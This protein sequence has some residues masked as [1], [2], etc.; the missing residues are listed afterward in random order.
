VRTL[1][2]IGAVALIAAACAFPAVARGGNVTPHRIDE[3]FLGTSIDYSHV[4]AWWGTSQPGLVDFAQG[5][6]V[7]RVD[8]TAGAQPDF[9]VSGQTR[10]AAHGDFD[11]RVHFDLATWPV[12]NGVWLSMLVGG[13]GYNVYRVS[14]QFP[15]SEAYGTFL[16]PVGTSLPATGT[17]G[18]LRLTRR[19]DIFTGYYL[20]GRSWIPIIS[21]TGPT[22]DQSLALGVFNLSA[23]ATFPGQPIAVAF[24][25]FH[26]LADRI[27]CP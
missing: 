24:D 21:G 3:T 15:E 14:W 18:T 17:S 20:A 7:L 16:P 26:V 22:G 5:G 1:A 23:I 9:N 11:A 8:V 10:C 2:R 6:G 25:N 27:V 4:W 12:Q 19:G 13:T